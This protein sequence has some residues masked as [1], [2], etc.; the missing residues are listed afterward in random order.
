MERST[1]RAESASV[2]VRVSADHNL[3]SFSNSK[4]ARVAPF[5]SPAA[6]ADSNSSRRSCATLTK[7]VATTSGSSTTTTD[8]GGVALGA[9]VGF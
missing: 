5:A 3:M 9:T 8:G 7:D 2:P 1:S 4:M 6:S